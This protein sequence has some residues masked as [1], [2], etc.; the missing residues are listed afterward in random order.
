MSASGPLERRIN[1]KFIFCRALSAFLLI[2]SVTLQAESAEPK[3]GADK[4]G[5]RTIEELHE[6]AETIA[7]ILETA[8]EKVEQ[9]SAA[10]AETP[11]LLEAIRQEISLSRRWNRHLGTIL[12]EVTEA[13]R[14]L[15]ERE[16]EAAKEIARMTAVAEEARLELN[17]LRNV[18]EGEGAKPEGSWSDS[19]L[20]ATTT[21]PVAPPTGQRIDDDLLSD[22]LRDTRLELAFM[23][24]AQT[25][26]LRDVEA[27]RAKIFEALQTLEVARIDR[28]VHRHRDGDLT[29]EDIMSWA[30]SMA[31]KLNASQD[32]HPD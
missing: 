19:K 28:T 21:L 22:S 9:L 20:D 3:T 29:D 12:R 10:N 14:A 27:V 32:R 6:H 24:E 18:L 17:A 5:E 7:V 13:R 23:Q 4:R 2:L 15:G 30:A 8:S 25:S 16:R 11:M 31:A 1:H 26:A